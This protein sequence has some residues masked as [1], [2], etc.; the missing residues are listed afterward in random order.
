MPANLGTMGNC[1]NIARGGTSCNFDITIPQND[2]TNK[3]YFKDV[4]VNGVMLNA[5]I[6]L[7]AIALLYDIRL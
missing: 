1:G 5:Y 7:A 6:D 2:T 3:K 4:Y